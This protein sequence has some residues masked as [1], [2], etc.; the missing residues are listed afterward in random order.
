VFQY[1]TRLGE[2]GTWLDDV[3]V[4]GVE[5]HAL[6]SVLLHPDGC[7]LGE[8]DEHLSEGVTLHLGP[9]FQVELVTCSDTQSNPPSPLLGRGNVVTKAT[10]A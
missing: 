6:G 9:L 4:F 5:H 8:A 2:V 3:C 10:C 7:G 1:P